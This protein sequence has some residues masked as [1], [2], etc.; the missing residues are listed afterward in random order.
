M[1]EDLHMILGVKLIR[2]TTGVTIT[3][4]SDLHCSQIGGHA[5]ELSQ[6]P[7]QRKEVYQVHH[8]IPS[9]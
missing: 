5:I 4:K 7:C 3:S 1:N 9:T 6:D 2:T 8:Q